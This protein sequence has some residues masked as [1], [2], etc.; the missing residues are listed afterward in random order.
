MVNK[1]NK[2]KL[3]MDSLKT[4]YFKGNKAVFEGLKT[5]HNNEY[6]FEYFDT[7]ND[8]L[9]RTDDFIIMLNIEHSSDMNTKENEI[10]LLKTLSKKPK[11]RIIITSFLP[12]RK[13][14]A[15]IPIA[16]E[17]DIIQLPCKKKI[18]INIE[19]ICNEDRVKQESQKPSFRSY[20]EHGVKN[21]DLA[22]DILSKYQDAENSISYYNKRI[23]IIIIDDRK[24]NSIREQFEIAR[25]SFDFKK[26]KG[27]PVVIKSF[28]NPYDAINYMEKNRWRYIKL[29]IIDYILYDN[30]ANK[31][32]D[33]SKKVLVDKIKN[34]NPFIDIYGVSAH[35]PESISNQTDIALQEFRNSLNNGFLLFKDDLLD[36]IKVKATFRRIFINPMNKRIQTPFF[37]KYKEYVNSE[38]QSWHVPGHNRGRALSESNFGKEFYDFFGKIA[39]AADHDVPKNFGTIFNSN[40]NSDS[41][42]SET[43]KL[44]AES[45]NT[46][47]TYFVTNGNSSAN[48]IILLS[49]LKPND[50]VLVARSCHKSIHYAMILSGAIP[51]YLESK[52]SEKYEIMAPPKIEDIKEKLKKAKEDNNPYKLVIVT[53]CGYEGLVMDVKKI[54]ELCKLYDSELF[55]DEAWYGYSRFHPKYLPTSAT[56]NGVPYVTQSVHKMLSA[57]RQ[58]AFIHV[59]SSKINREFLIDIYNTF[60]STSPQYQ[61]I[62]SMDIAVMQMRMEGFE[63][64]DYALERCELFKEDFRNRGLHKI[65][66]VE[67]DDL[68][69]EF[70]KPELDF[71]FEMENIF[72]D[73]LKISFDIS[74]LGVSSKVAFEYLKEKANIDLVKYTKNCIQIL[75][76]IGT[77]TD[78]TKQSNFITALCK[79]EEI[80]KEQKVIITGG[81]TIQ[82][83]NPKYVIGNSPRDYFYKERDRKSVV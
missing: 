13:V 1:S 28:G 59:N 67:Y 32:Y 22:M 29:I 65:K 51:T 66:L 39:F 2:I 38:S 58:S 35:D 52:Y 70:I 40:S 17:F 41:A 45:Y 77:A 78:T 14:I 42:I 63:V 72:Y 25:D 21:E 73:P 15:E 7:P 9:S 16:E 10:F 54:N 11:R 57:F 71:D 47:N 53:G 5:F 83:D 30:E 76:T 26:I 6:N 8:I 56:Y 50:K 68:K 33:L 27:I 34:S 80:N 44:I 49:I 43:Q 24:H 81:S 46:G 4:I 79:M 19:K 23:E 31:E 36:P 48:N 20:L 74:G 64:I 3:N 60:T 37:T 55:V 82:L 62:A 12:S 61:L 18:A 69:S 75:F